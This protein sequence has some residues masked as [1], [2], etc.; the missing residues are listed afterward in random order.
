MVSDGRNMPSNIDSLIGEL[1]RIEQDVPDKIGDTIE[2]TLREVRR[3]ARQNLRENG[4][5][6]SFE[7]SRSLRIGTPVGGGSQTY[8]LGTPVRYAQYVEF[9]TGIYF[10]GQEHTS[11]YGTPPLTDRLIENIED[12]MATKGVVPRTPTLSQRDVAYLIA[13]RISDIGT[14][15]QP[16]L[17]PAWESSEET[18]EARVYLAANAAL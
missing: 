16:F 18:L 8:T 5:N 11:P 12:W 2:Q 3:K 6:A 15:A 13:D 17:E 14:E 4:T 9:G 10:Q 7:L 1:E